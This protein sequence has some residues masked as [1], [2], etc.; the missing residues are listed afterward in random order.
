VI[1]LQPLKQ[2][3]EIREELIEALLLSARGNSG[4]IAAQFFSAFVLIE[5]LDELN[6]I[7]ERGGTWP[8]KPSG[9]PNPEPCC[10]FSMR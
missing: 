3:F 2:P 4:N 10:Q 7:A 1:S 8:G 9:S 6:E 5:S